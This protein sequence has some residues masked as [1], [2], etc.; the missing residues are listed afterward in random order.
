VTGD[1]R[2]FAHATRVFLGDA[3]P[4]GRVRLDAVAR[5]LQ[6]A[7]YLDVLD[8]GFEGQGAWVVRRSRIEVER[9][10]VVGEPVRATTWCS[11]LG[12]MWAERRTTIEG[13]RGGRAEATALWVHVDLGSGRPRPLDAAQLAFW[14]A[15]AGDRRVRA[16]LQHDDPPEGAPPAPWH[17]RAADLDIAG[18]VNNAAFWAIV[19][20]DLAAGG[21][22]PEPVTAEIEHRGAAAAGPAVVLRVQDRWWI[23]S[24]TGE[25]RASIRLTMDA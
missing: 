16:R 7:A 9:F 21:G 6:D 12:K 4:D 18:H 17:F 20:E 15:S 3:A 24:A 25:A 14:G 2:R 1:G 8:A 13:E 22:V 10:P 23:C 5:W 11:G 19:E